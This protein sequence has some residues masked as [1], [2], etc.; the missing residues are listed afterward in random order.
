MK[1]II[2]ILTLGLYGCDKIPELTDEQKEE[3]RIAHDSLELYR[4]VRWTYDGQW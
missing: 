2:L 3:T 1:Y 4:S